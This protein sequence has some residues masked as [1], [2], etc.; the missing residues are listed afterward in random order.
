[1]VVPLFV[2]KRPVG[3]DRVAV[4]PMAAAV[5]HVEERLV[6]G[7]AEAVGK[8]EARVDD[9]VGSRGG[10]EVDLARGPAVPTRLGG[11]DAAGGCDDNVVSPPALRQHLRLALLAPGEDRLV[12]GAGGDQPS[13][14]SEALAVAT[15]GVFE[16]PLWLPVG[17][18][19]PCLP[20]A[21]IVVVDIP[22]G[23]DRGAFGE[24]VAFA[25][26]HP[27]LTG[28]ENLLELRA[29]C[30]A[31]NRRGPSFP[32][33]LDRVGEDLRGVLVVVAPVAPRMVHLVAGERQR[34]LKG[35][36]GDPPIAAIDVEVL[37]SALEKDADRL[38]LDL[39][40]EGGVFIAAAQS[41]VRADPAE[42][43][44]EGVR[45]L[46]GGGE[47]G[48]RATRGAPDGAV[49]ARLRE[50]DRPPVRGFSLLDVGEELVEEEAGVGVPQAV[51]FVTAVE[52]V[53]GSVAAGGDAAVHDEYSDRHR[54][55][56][57][58]DQPIEHLRSVELD[59]ILIDMDTRRGGAVILRRDIHP[60]VADGAGKHPAVVE[61]ELE[62]LPLGGFLGSACWG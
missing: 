41:D 2:G 34:P 12:G 3:G 62:N 37:G 51:V 32:Q 40:H 50:D 60:V 49:V 17:R 16:P 10:D 52:A 11:I 46:P 48:D 29:S 15:V 36:V 44:A 28:D 58:V 23:V 43:T 61:A 8:Q 26:E 19:S 22:A 30:P 5:G 24:A 56:L 54:H 38:R 53:E 13:I 18:Q 14:G 39:P 20:L 47:G 42:D 1:M 31:C 33:P 4:H 57:L 9:G 35:L 7:E 55:P 59:P 27:L 25:D 21:D 6:G 45:P